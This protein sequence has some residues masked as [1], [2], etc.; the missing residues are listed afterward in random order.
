MWRDKKR[1]KYREREREKINGWEVGR[2]RNED[3]HDANS[4]LITH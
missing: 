3:Y 1:E 2:G 4:T